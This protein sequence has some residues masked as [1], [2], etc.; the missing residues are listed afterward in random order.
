[1]LKVWCD[2][3]C[4]GL[5]SPPVS[6][7]MSMNW[8]KGGPG[9]KRGFGFGG[10]SLAGKKEEPPL[11]NK[12]H[13]SFGPTGS[14]GGYGKNQQLPSFYKIGTKRANFDEENAWVLHLS[15]THEYT[16]IYVQPLTEQW[17]YDLICGIYFI[18]KLHICYFQ[19]G[20]LKTMKRSPAAM[21]ICRTS[22]LRTLPHGSRCSL[23]VAQTVKMT[24]W[25]P[26]WQRLR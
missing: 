24:H 7:S 14:A 9:V 22:Q 12:S 13:T 4:W 1:M 19:P 11:P 21:L 8:N 17:I 26:S 16:Y 15:P 6:Y 23:V 3:R 10:F 5:V 2:L 25:M 20:T 18:I